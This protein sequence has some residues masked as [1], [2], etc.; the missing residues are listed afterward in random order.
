MNGVTGFCKE[1]PDDDDEDPHPECDALNS[2]CAFYSNFPVIYDACFIDYAKAC[3]DDSGSSDPY[4]CE[5]EESCFDDYEC[6]D[7]DCCDSETALCKKCDIC[8]NLLLFS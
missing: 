3:C 1:A 8:S 2:C 6:S 7:G 4:C 5:I